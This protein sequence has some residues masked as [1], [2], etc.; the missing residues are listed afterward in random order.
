LEVVVLREALDN[1]TV[2]PVGSLLLIA[3]QVKVAVLALVT[4]CSVVMVVRVAV[5]A[6]SWAGVEVPALK[7][8]TVAEETQRLTSPVAV[9]AVV[10][11][12]NKPQQIEVVTAAQALLGIFTLSEVVV[13]AERS[14]AELL[15]WVALVAGQT[16]QLAGFKLLTLRQGRVEVEVA[17]VT[18]WL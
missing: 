12:V 17:Q 4:N 2:V 5:Q 14:E 13:V 18:T 11:T 8:V 9:G 7:V 3:K 1:P 6:P 16:V 10:A 15:D